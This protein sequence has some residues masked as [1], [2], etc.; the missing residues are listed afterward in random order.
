MVG[1]NAMHIV[2]RIIGRGLAA[3]LPII[4]TVAILVWL[5]R[6]IETWMAVPLRW[7]MGEVYLPGMGLVVGLGLIIVLGIVASTWIGG[8][9]LDLLNAIVERLPLVKTIYGALKDVFS[10]FTRKESDSFDTAVMVEW[11]GRRFL[12][13]ITREDGSGLPDGLMNEGD[14]IVY[15]PMGYQIGGFPIVVPRDQ[16]TPIDMSV[17]EAL[18]FALTAGA[19]RNG[20]T[21]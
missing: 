10:L 8:K 14:V 17:D 1:A 3:G 12:G 20:G 16:L 13:F 18:K 4:L 21:S 19:S 7:V 11:G 2:T 5:L 6:T 9:L 15:L